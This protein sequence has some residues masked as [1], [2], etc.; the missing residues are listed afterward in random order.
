MAFTGESRA[1]IKL[2]I[3]IPYWHRRVLLVL[4]LGGF[5]T[6]KS[7]HEIVPVHEIL[8]LKEVNELLQ[9]KHI[10]LENLPKILESDPQCT[11]LGAKP[12][13]VVRISRSDNGNAYLYYRVVVEG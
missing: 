7:D 6:G 9:G 1:V 4:V 11:K 3:Y 2:I 8:K 10:T 5:L 12:G 13:H